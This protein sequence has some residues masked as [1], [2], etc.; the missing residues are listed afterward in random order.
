M[1]NE[2]GSYSAAYSNYVL[3]VLFLV[4]VFNFIDRQVLGILLDD[5][6]ADLQ[7]S[8]TAMGFLVGFAFVVF[9][10]FAG[11]PIARWADRSSRRGIIALGLTVW[12]GMTALS[13]MAQN[14][15]QLALA[16]V[17]VGIGEAAGSPPA[18]SL[19][20]DYFPP[21]RRATALSIYAGGVYIGSMIA[22]LAGGY[23]KEILS[24]RAAFFLVGIPGLLLALV[25][26]YT[27]KEPP[28]GMSEGVTV[29]AEYVGVGEVLRYLVS[30]RSFVFIIIA[31]SVQSLSGYSVLVWGPAFLGRVHDMGG[32]NIGTWLGI[33]IG[34]AGC[35][36]AYLG[37]KLSDVVGRRDTRWYMRLPAIESLLGVPCVIGFLLSDS[38]TEALFFFAPFFLLGAM[39]VGPMFAMTQGLVK[40]RM[41]A[42]AS[43]I[44][45]FVVNMI[46]L[47]LAPLLVGFMND[48][49]FAVHGDRAI[50]Y[51]LLVMGISG[52][53]AS[54]FFWL[55]SV[56]LRE[57]LARASA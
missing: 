19:I 34:V 16:R 33:I 47:G 50:R 54:I 13:G 31:S 43:A 55:A 9:Y 5:I 35:L 46:G 56:K 42:T 17:G 28:R 1:Q 36:G 7:V 26:R 6:K 30:C 8:D 37:G 25:V 32:I 14:F 53:L 52:G 18:H 29:D 11:I 23:I 45:L 57:D 21:R 12:S 39:Y 2:R 3:A 24:W 49:L 27:I 10:T 4:Y 22:Y 44:L 41:R 20:A 51:S 38:P 40:L 15:A 48:T